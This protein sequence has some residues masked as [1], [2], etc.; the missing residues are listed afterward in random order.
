MAETTQRCPGTRATTT[1]RFTWDSGSGDYIQL[2][3][4]D[5]DFLDTAR[6]RVSDGWSFDHNSSTFTKDNVYTEDGALVLRMHK[7]ASPPP[8]PP[9][10]GNPPD[11][12]LTS[13]VYGRTCKSHSTRLT[14]KTAKTPATLATPSETHSSGN[15]PVKPAD[16]C[17]S[18]GLLRDTP[19]QTTTPRK[20]LKALAMAAPNA[21]PAT[22][23]TTLLS[24]RPLRR[25]PDAVHPPPST[26][27]PVSAVCCTMVSAVETASL[28][29]GR[30]LKVTPLAVALPKEL[31]VALPRISRTSSGVWSV[32]P[33]LMETVAPIAKSV[34]TRGLSRRARPTL[35][36]SADA[37]T[38][39]Q[40]EKGGSLTE[41]T[42]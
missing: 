20:T 28:A 4:D 6:W 19:I 41:K 26:N 22:Q 27:T 29:S 33:N 8:A 5:F 42:E 31:A 7:T 35:T 39:T 15:P 36:P 16:A 21:L 25:W 30:G 24:T 34:A 13:Y 3:R 1:S 9:S 37:K 10:G 38:G 17:P 2:W 18:R 32:Q 23:M 40:T 11:I 14:V 12:E